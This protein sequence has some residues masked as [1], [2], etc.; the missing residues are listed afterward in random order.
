MS[1][2]PPDRDRSTAI[3]REI[4]LRNYDHDAERTVSLTLD[5]RDEEFPRHTVT[6]RLAPGETYCPP[7]LA[8]RGAYRITATLSDGRQDS[9]VCSLGSEFEETVLVET[10]NGTISVTPAPKE[11]L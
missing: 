8:P 7:E 4:V 6:V 1:Q 5:P 11:L 3:T 2:Q 9:A 10:G